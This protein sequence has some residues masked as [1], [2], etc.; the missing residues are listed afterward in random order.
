MPQSRRRTVIMAAAPGEILPTFPEP[1][2]CFA[3]MPS[4]NL[5][6]KIGGK[7]F[8]TPLDRMEAAPFRTVTCRDVFSDLPE[9]LPEE[10]VKIVPDF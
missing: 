3:R 6:V 8:S 1:Q 9:L 5:N 2:H 10:S 4:T 7:R